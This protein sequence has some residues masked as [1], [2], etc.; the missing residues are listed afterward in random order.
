MDWVEKKQWECGLKDKQM[1]EEIGK[2][3]Y[4]SVKCVT[5]GIY[6]ALSAKDCAHDRDVTLTN[7][8]IYSHRQTQTNTHKNKHAKARCI[9]SF[10]SFFLS[11]NNNWRKLLCTVAK[12]NGRR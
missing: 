12:N 6:S 5:N 11:E 10:L 7:K 1:K 9:F 4:K 2:S 8:Y 3:I